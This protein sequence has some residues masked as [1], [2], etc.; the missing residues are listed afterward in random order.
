MKNLKI[1]FHKKY[2]YS[3]GKLKKLPH[4]GW[5]AISIGQYTYICT[6]YWYFD[7]YDSANC[8]EKQS[9]FLIT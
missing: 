8:L 2:K 7:I 1:C 3:K 5:Q 6:Y 9:V 4:E